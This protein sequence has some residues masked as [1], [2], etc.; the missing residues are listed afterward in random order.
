MAN[1]V[2]R[3]LII[4]EAERRG[5]RVDFIGPNEYICQV[6]DS[7]G[8]MEMF[9]SSRP[10]RS[11]A[12]GTAITIHKD[13]TLA[14]VQSRGY[15]VPAYIA[16]DDAA[17]A[18]A[19]LEQ[20]QTIV[21]KPTDAQQSAGVTIN[22]TTQQQLTE[23]VALAR[24]HSRSSNV[25]LQKQI[26]G[27]LYRIF[28]INGKLVAAAHRSAAQVVGDGQHTIAK[29]T[30]ELNQDPR[31]SD[32]NSAPLKR[33]KLA[34]VE[35]FLG[36]EGL[37]E[38]PPAGLG[39]RISSIDSV[40]AGG[41]SADVT[42]SV[43]PDWHKACGELAQGIGLFVC[44]FDIICEDISQ[45]IRDNYLPLLEMNS[46]PGLKLHHYPTAGGEAI[47]VVKILFDELFEA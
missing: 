30:V 41:E 9:L 6:T 14:Y 7:R 21:V 13:V 2:S 11:S 25:I 22:V 33:V 23:A 35:A 15:Q 27:K 16:F 1:S 5:W 4:A 26:E 19:F 20:H 38:I 17:S 45:P 47:D 12:N 31:R 28:V 40:S 18:H 37:Q 29:L 34:D 10:L 8:R 3:T 32:D 39:V 24:T 46:A 44:G 43:H 42:V 36:R